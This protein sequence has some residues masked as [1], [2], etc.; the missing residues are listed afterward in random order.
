MSRHLSVA[1]CPIPWRVS[2]LEG[3]EYPCT[4]QSGCQPT[5]HPTMSLEHVHSRTPSAGSHPVDPRTV[6]EGVGKVYIVSNL[7][8][9]NWLFNVHQAITCTDPRP[10]HLLQLPA[11]PFQPS[12]I[13]MKFSVIAIAA[14]AAIFGQASPVPQDSSAV[15][16]L[17]KILE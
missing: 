10:S 9:S 14:A 7:R 4:A 3:L 16:R 12:T 2:K 13:T 1:T 6:Q 11:N 5:G 15:S 17:W 8:S